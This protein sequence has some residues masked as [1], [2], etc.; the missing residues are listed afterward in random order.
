MAPPDCLQIPNHAVFAA[1]F[2]R[3]LSKDVVRFPTDLLN[4]HLLLYK[5][6]FSYNKNNK[7]RNANFEH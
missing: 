2:P 6:Q 7:S 1:D 4:Y 5:Q 3:G